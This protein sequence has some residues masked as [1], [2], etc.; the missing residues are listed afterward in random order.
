[1]TCSAALFRWPVALLSLALATGVLSSCGSADDASSAGLAERVSSAESTGSDEA[2]ASTSEPRATP[3][4]SEQELHDRLAAANASYDRGAQALFE[5]GS[6]VALG[7]GGS[8]VFDLTPLRGAPIRRLDL[9]H[10]NVRSLEGL[11]GMPLEELRLVKT[12]RPRLVSDPQR[13]AQGSRRE[14]HARR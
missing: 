11:E 3:P 13:E 5:G 2:S 8:T 7:L 10:T 12:G 14:P 9:S 4:S 1:M 6:L